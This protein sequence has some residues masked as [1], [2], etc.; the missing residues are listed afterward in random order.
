MSAS[1]ISQDGPNDLIGSAGVDDGR[2]I[3]G[4]RGTGDRS[5]GRHSTPKRYST[6]RT[7]NSLTAIAET[8]RQNSGLRRPRPPPPHASAAAR[9]E[10]RRLVGRG[11]GWQGDEEARATVEIAGLGGARRIEPPLRWTRSLAMAS[12]SPDPLSRA[13]LWKGS[14]IWARCSAGKPGPLSLTSISA[15]EAETR[16]AAKRIAAGRSPRSPA[17]VQSL[18]R[19]AAQILE[20][21]A[22]MFGIGDRSRSSAECRWRS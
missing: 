8:R 15:S 7:A 1:V 13:E 9:S 17:L 16:I 14:K 19:V 20:N 21:A 6:A 11:R 4:W 2:A 5:S 18:H 3:W 10:R 22:H 12:S